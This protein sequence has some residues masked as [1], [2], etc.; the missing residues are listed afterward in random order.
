MAVKK[1]WVQFIDAQNLV[2]V[3]GIPLKAT[4]LLFSVTEFSWRSMHAMM[5]PYLV[6]DLFC[7]FI[8]DGVRVRVGPWRWFKFSVNQ[9]AS[10]V[11]F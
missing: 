11:K 2:G 5:I 3:S 4:S 9:R 1:Q 6:F 10:K 7:V 8:D